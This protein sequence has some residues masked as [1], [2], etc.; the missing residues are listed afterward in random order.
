MPMCPNPCTRKHECDHPVRHNCHSD[1]KCPK[2]TFL[3]DKKCKCGRNEMKNIPCFLPSVSCGDVCGRMLACQVHSCHKTCHTGP[4]EKDGEKCTQKCIRLRIQCGHPCGAQCH[5]N[6]SDCPVSECQT[7]I[8]LKC[9]CGRLKQIARCGIKNQKTD[10][11]EVEIDKILECDKECKRQKRLKQIA[12]A[13]KVDV[14]TSG[15]PPTEYPSELKMRAMELG[16]KYVIGIEEKIATLVHETIELKSPSR[17]LYFEA[18][19]WKK[20]EFV[21]ALAEFYG[22]SGLSQGWKSNRF[23]MIDARFGE[24]YTPTRSITD[25]LEADRRIPKPVAILPETEPNLTEHGIMERTQLANV[26][27]ELNDNELNQD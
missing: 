24:C 10:N 16:M 23:V 15:L 22:C 11:I 19:G 27:D 26:T 25:A 14:N 17:T 8:L 4:C 9:E 7:E 21:K 6:E 3:V 5:G 18:C 13:L 12:D 20:R 2:C 1:P